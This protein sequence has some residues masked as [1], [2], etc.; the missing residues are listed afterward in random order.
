MSEAE[1]PEKISDFR[2]VLGRDQ[3]CA[4]PESGEPS[5]LR[6]FVPN[7]FDAQPGGVCLLD[8]HLAV[9]N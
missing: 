2:L 9:K 4:T 3:K 5:G 7:K 8:N 6:M 1:G